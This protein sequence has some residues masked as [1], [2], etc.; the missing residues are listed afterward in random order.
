MWASSSSSVSPDYLAG[1][2][3]SPAAASARA[4]VF[5]WMTLAT[6]PL[7]GFLAERSG[8]PDVMLA[9][10]LLLFA[11][12]VA[13]LVAWDGPAVLFVALGVVGGVPAGI[14]MALPA[15]AV[16]AEALAP[17]MG[18]YF[19]VYYVGMTTLPAA[20]GW[21]RDATGAPAA[22]LLF[23]A[24]MMILTLAA[25]ALFRWRE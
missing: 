13:G 16:R 9:L 15:R 3:L 5:V 2:G 19:T 8:R 4:S 14:I 6:V 18:L 11:V 7:G 12:A 20:A 1:L 10:A 22:P 25:L 24:A 23:A 21:S 17:A